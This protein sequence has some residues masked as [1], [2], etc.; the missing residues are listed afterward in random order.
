MER[1]ETLERAQKGLF[2]NLSD[3]LA[4]GNADAIRTISHELENVE[5]AIRRIRGEEEKSTLL[6]G[7]K[8][9]PLGDIMQGGEDRRAKFQDALASRMNAGFDSFNINNAIRERI[10]QSGG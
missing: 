2:Q 9:N 1:I 10:R 8:R 7:L 4:S 6:R 3:A 5:R